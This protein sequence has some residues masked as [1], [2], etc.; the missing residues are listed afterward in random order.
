[1][2]NKEITE[3]KWKKTIEKRGML[4]KYK[5]GNKVIR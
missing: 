5:R 2:S 3:I 1:M 4:R